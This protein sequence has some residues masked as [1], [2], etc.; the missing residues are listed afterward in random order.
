MSAVTITDQSSLN[1]S[2]EKHAQAASRDSVNTAHTSN[3]ATASLAM[4]PG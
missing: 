4:G 1:V 3:A 2:A